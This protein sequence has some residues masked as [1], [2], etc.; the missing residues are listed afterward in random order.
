[1]RCVNIIIHM[2]LFFVYKSA[3]LYVGMCVCVH[4]CMCVHVHVQFCVPVCG[5]VCV[6]VGVCTMKW[7]YEHDMVR[8][9]HVH[10]I[11]CMHADMSSIMLAFYYN[12]QG[13]KHHLNGNQYSG[14]LHENTGIESAN[15]PRDQKCQSHA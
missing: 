9:I 14:G 11:A 5:C 6:C 3:Y 12:L 8:I 1:M 13:R 7:G 10:N 4:A 15:P 2:T